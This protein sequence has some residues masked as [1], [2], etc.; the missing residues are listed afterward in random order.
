MWSVVFVSLL[1][2]WLISITCC[3]CVCFFKPLLV[4]EF[5]PFSL[6]E[7][8]PK[9]C[10]CTCLNWCLFDPCHWF[11][12]INILSRA[13]ACYRI[14]QHFRIQWP[15]TDGGTMAACDLPDYLGSS[16]DAPKLSDHL[17]ALQKLLQLPGTHTHTQKKKEVQPTGLT[18]A[19]H[20][21]EFPQSC[22][23]S[24][25]AIWQ[26][27]SHSSHILISVIMLTRFSISMKYRNR[28]AH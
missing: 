22:P 4:G 3:C 27:D 19:S 15:V 1:S 24:T 28:P 8:L 14:L 25:S 9:Y 17:Q 12:I 16:S 7:C 23:M 6:P 13:G 2:C 26:L 20:S 21:M 5:I 18:H 11:P 10:M